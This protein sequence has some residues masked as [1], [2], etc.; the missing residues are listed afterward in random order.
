M[1][2]NPSL[3]VDLSG[4]YW[5]KDEESLRRVAALALLIVTPFVHTDGEMLVSTKCRQ[6]SYPGGKQQPNLK[7]GQQAPPQQRA[8]VT[9]SIR[10]E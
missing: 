6:Q 4:V 10:K 5:E 2:I 8:G 7:L 3:D 1:G 9:G